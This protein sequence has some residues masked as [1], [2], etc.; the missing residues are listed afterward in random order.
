RSSKVSDLS[1]Q[2]LTVLPHSARQRR[3]LVRIYF[4]SFAEHL[5]RVSQLAIEK[6]FHMSVVVS[7][8]LTTWSSNVA[9]ANRSHRVFLTAKVSERLAPN[10]SAVSAADMH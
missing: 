1:E 5:S 4:G 6:D 8:T 7:V 2:L 3:S 9:D 10:F